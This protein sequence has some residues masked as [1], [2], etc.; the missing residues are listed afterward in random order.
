M[1]RY[2]SAISG[3]DAPAGKYK[4]A[5][6]EFVRLVA[7]AHEDAGRVAVASDQNE[8]CCIT[9]ANSTG[10]WSV[11]YILHGIKLGACR[12]IYKLSGGTGETKLLQS[13][14]VLLE[15][16]GINQG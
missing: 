8:G 13:G 14:G 11:D 16:V 12:S 9:R 1:P 7:L 15:R 4:F 3:I 2:N 10:M 5:R 6:H